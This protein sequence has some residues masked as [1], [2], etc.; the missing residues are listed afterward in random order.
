M[1]FACLSN[2]IQKAALKHHL[3]DR[4]ILKQNVS[5]V[6]TQKSPNT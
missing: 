3:R 6:L 4:N 1:S 2:V 5:K